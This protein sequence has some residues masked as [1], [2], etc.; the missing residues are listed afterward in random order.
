MF[1]EKDPN[2]VSEFTFISM[3]VNSVFW[4]INFYRLEDLIATLP[5]YF[6]IL[7]R[8]IK[9]RST[10]KCYIPDDLFDLQI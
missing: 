9:K 5:H 4:F 10:N 6:G 7:K 2:V 3:I 8:A 1:K